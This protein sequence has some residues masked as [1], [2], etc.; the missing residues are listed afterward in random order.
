MQIQTAAVAVNS[1][2]ARERERERLQESGGTAG[3]SAGGERRGGWRV[4]W[5]KG[6]VRVM[7]G[8]TALRRR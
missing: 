8:A 7:L 1:A 5:V 3:P 4:H 2:C 6:D